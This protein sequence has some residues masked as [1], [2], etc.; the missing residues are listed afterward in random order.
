[1]K[2]TFILALPLFLLIMGCKS[3]PAANP[4]E[5]SLNTAVRQAASLMETRL[6]AGTKIALINFNSP[7]AAFSEY[8]LD[9]LSS[10]LVNDGVLVV[11]D[12]ASLDKVRQ[13]LNF[14]M[15]GEVS[16]QSA[17]E[18]G[19]MLGAEAIVTGSLVSMGDL[20]RVM[21]KAIITQT[22]AV[23][24]Q[25]PA[26]IINDRRVQALLAS[27]AKASAGGGSQAIAYNGQGGGGGNTAGSGTTGGP[28][29]ATPA[30]PAN[31]TYTFWPRLRASNAGLPAEVYIPQIIVT[32]EYTVIFFS[33]VAE[34]DFSN[35]MRGFYDVKAFTLQ[36]LNNPS[37]FYDIASARATDN[38]MGRIYSLSYKRFTSTRFKLSLKQ[39][40]SDQQ[41]YV[42]EEIVLGEPDE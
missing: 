30:G 14:N 19:K 25:H 11:V 37:K 29:A 22:A 15:S 5:V 27:D 7:S 16:D 18:I 39:Y 6:E 24:V 40:S 34:G 4:D 2:R 20:R 10:V 41:P 38:G 32:G 31:G 42:F 26:D 35:G 3:V 21:F 1:M 23:A 33:G 28:A 9:E 8:V 36:D 13:E 12:R 17:Q